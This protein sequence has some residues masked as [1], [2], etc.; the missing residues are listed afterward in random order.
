MPH[1][2]RSST[3][4]SPLIPRAGGQAGGQFPTPSMCIHRTLYTP[5][6]PSSPESPAFPFHHNL[7][8]R[9]GW[10]QATRGPA[11]T[12]GGDQPLR[13]PASFMRSHHSPT[14]PPLAHG[15]KPVSPAQPALPSAGEAGVYCVM[16]PYINHPQVASPTLPYLPV[17][18]Q[19]GCSRVGYMYVQC[20]SPF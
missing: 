13:R 2:P 15:Q 8:P 11:P 5:P 10:M 17:P 1:P 16:C 12:S 20:T 6:E 18:M 4:P 7:T 9:T 3:K 14:R 19:G